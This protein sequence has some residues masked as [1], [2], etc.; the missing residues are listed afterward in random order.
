MKNPQLKCF[1]IEMQLFAPGPPTAWHYVSII[2]LPLAMSLLQVKFSACL[3]SVILPN[4]IHSILWIHNYNYV[5]LLGII[6]SR[7]ASK[8]VFPDMLSV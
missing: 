6:A 7:D 3:S 5:D 8:T 2:I 1:L 4:D